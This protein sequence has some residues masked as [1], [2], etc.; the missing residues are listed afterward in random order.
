M[1]AITVAVLLGLM[2]LSI[3]VA[4]VLIILGLVLDQ[5]FAF[6]PL[7]NALGEIAWSASISP[8]MVAIPL[9]ILLGSGPIDFR[10]VA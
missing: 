7:I 6:F 5:G 1:I 2:A 9:F 10:S 4:A 8:S 3:P